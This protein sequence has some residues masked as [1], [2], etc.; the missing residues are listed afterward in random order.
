MSSWYEA[1]RHVYSASTLVLAILP[2]GFMIRLTHIVV[3]V[4][5]GKAERISARLVA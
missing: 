1:L 4:G 2:E 3:L 5:E